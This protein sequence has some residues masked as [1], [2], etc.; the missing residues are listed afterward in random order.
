MMTYL[1][2]FPKKTIYFYMRFLLI[3]I[4]SIRM[5]SYVFALRVMN[6]NRQILPSQLVDS[7]NYEHSLTLL[8]MLSFIF[9]SM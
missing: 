7:Y 6:F 1:F 4:K 5:I 2:W 3:H 8:F 9:D